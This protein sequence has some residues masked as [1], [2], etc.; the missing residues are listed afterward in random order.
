MIFAEIRLPIWVL[1]AILINNV[2]AFGKDWNKV[3]E[4]SNKIK[5]EHAHTD[6]VSLFR[7]L[8]LIRELLHDELTIYIP[9]MYRYIY[10][11][12]VSAALALLR[13]ITISYDKCIESALLLGKGISHRNNYINLVSVVKRFFP[14]KLISSIVDKYYRSQLIVCKNALS[15]QI[16]QKMVHQRITSPARFD[17][18]FTKDLITHFE[19]SV[20]VSQLSRSQLITG[21]A[22]YLRNKLKH[23][24]MLV[25]TLDA[26]PFDKVHSKLIEDCKNYLLD[27]YQTLMM[28]YAAIGRSNMP[29]IKAKYHS[30]I[31][32]YDLCRNI[33]RLSTPADVEQLK[34]LINEFA[35]ADS[36]SSRK[37]SRT[38]SF[39]SIERIGS[40][41]NKSNQTTE[42]PSF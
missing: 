33:E 7:D 21:I 3:V 42:K 27:P 2:S 22:Q 13:A 37:Q 35:R 4:I 23:D 15:I 9:Q 6:T 32:A 17:Q 40:S 25:I 1:I 11:F 31:H 41:S 8:S 24:E 34:E 10:D 26:S 16:R 28:T 39:Q 38:F 29:N 14:S 18:K 20:D 36:S 12:S 30:L 19:P 5:R